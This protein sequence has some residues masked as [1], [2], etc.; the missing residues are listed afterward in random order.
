MITTGAAYALFAEGE[1]GVIA[2]G[3]LADLVVLSADPQTTDPSDL[4]GVATAM[5][6]VAGEVRWCAASFAAVCNTITAANADRARHM[7]SATLAGSEPRAAFDGDTET[8]WIS[9]GPAQQWI[10]VEFPEPRP[11]TELRLVVAQDPAG[12]VEHMVLAG[13]HDQALAVVATIAQHA[14]D[15][16]VITVPLQLH[17]IRILRVVTAVSPSWVAWREIEVRG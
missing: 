6:L 14:A 11:I 10:Q 16:T 17:G 15:G 12:S 8:A 9:G 13:P 3:A 5:T 2:P 7:A 4:L 1:R